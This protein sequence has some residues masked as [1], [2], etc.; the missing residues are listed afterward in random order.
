[1][2]DGIQDAWLH[3][4]IDLSGYLGQ[5]IKLRFHLVSDGGTNYDGLYFDD[6]NVQKIVSAQNSISQ[7]SNLN[8]SISVYPN[9]N[10]GNFII[11]T[12]TE[13]HCIM[14]DVNGVEVLNQ[15][16]TGKTNI[17]TYNLSSG[18]YNLSI[19]S[20]ESII[21]KKVFNIFMMNI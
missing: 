8:T 16:V 2:Y 18:V 12:K 14:Y 20:N 9:P 19:I 10:N 1:M 7:I 4:I 15:K 21:N 17:E 6:I 3:E 5:N 13:V 11:D